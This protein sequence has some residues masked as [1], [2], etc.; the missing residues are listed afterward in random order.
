MYKIKI[1]QLD[2]HA[3]CELFVNNVYSG[4]LDFRKDELPEFLYCL[5]KFQ[6]QIF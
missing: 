5:G 2:S 4:S 6:V 1:T 3:H